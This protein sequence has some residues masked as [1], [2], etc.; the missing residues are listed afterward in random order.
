MTGRTLRRVEVPDEVIVH[1]LG[2]C[3][4]CGT[5]LATA[6]VVSIEARQVFDPPVIRL[7]VAEHRIERRHFAGCG[8]VTMA[9]PPRGVGAPT[10]YGHGVRAVANY[11]VGAQHLPYE[12]TAGVLADLLARRSRPEASRPGSPRP[13]STWTVSPPRCVN[14]CPAPRWP[15]SIRPGWG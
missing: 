14:T 13:P 15:D 4:G 2:S 12:R 5:S 10:R 11:L 7:L 8:T 1:A 9:G 3:A 6:A